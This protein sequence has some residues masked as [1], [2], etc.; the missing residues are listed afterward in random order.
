MADSHVL[1]KRVAICVVYLRAFET[2][3]FDA[4]ILI[5]DLTTVLHP[6]NG[7]RGTRFP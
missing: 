4:Y 1:D 6:I 5:E 2:A 7:Y 3:L